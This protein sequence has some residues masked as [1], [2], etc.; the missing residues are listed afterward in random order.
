MAAGAG[1]ALAMAAGAAAMAV[2]A[3]EAEKS[4]NPMDDPTKRNIF[5]KDGNVV[6]MVPEGVLLTAGK[7]SVSLFKSG[8]INFTAPAGITINPGKQLSVN[9][10]KI[11]ITAGTTLEIKDE[12]GADVKLLKECI[13]LKAKEI[14]EN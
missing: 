8:N 2:K 13:F 5:T 3:A 4:E 10:K 6:Q 1:G 7:S 9:G 14:Y 11:A 12:A